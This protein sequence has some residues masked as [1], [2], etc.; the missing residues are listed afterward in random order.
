MNVWRAH[1]EEVQ[2]LKYPM[3]ESKA[4]DETTHLLRD[5]ANTVTAQASA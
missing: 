4:L 1:L 2:R 5:I 3:N